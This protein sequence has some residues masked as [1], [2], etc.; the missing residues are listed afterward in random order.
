MIIYN[1]LKDLD[2]NDIIVYTNGL[3]NQ[4]IDQDNNL[5]IK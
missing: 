5:H 2:I 4:Y 1:Q 3:L